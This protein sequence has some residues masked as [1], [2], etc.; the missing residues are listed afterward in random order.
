MSKN[1]DRVEIAG[2][3]H[4]NRQYTVQEKFRLVDQIPQP[5]TTVPV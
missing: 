1:V 4:H 2:G 5:G 3:T